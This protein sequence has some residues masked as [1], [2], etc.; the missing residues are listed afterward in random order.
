M[1]LILGCTNFLAIG[2]IANVLRQTD[3][4]ILV[5]G[6]N[7]DQWQVIIWFPCA[8]RRFKVVQM[9]AIERISGRTVLIAL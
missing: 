7:R 4:L 5:V 2:G 9:D 1:R 8:S 6:D 3:I